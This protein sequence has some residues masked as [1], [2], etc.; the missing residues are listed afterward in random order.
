[1]TVNNKIPSSCKT[2]LLT[3]QQ[4]IDLLPDQWPYFH[5]FNK[6]SEVDVTVSMRRPDSRTRWTRILKT[7]NG[8][9]SGK[10]EQENFEKMNVYN[11]TL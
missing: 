9:V 3:G 8:Y 10:S 5:W 11:K 1:M 2:V 7:S 6:S 4:F